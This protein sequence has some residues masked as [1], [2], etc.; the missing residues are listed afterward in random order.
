VSKKHEKN[1]V[2]LTD[3]TV[4]GDELLM[5]RTL[6][7]YIAQQIETTEDGRELAALSRQYADMTQ[8]INVLE[9]SRPKP[10]RRTALDDARNKRKKAPV[11]RKPGTAN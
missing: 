8:R 4:S 3:A 6:R 9:K 1:G 5:L 7:Y 11:K 2:S 10:D